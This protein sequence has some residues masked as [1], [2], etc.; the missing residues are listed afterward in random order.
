[1][2]TSDLSCG[3]WDLLW[4]LE[5]SLVEVQELQQLQC[6][7][8]V[9][10]GY[11]GRRPGIEPTSPALQGRYLTPGPPGKSP[12]IPLRGEAKS[13]AESKGPGWWWGVGADRD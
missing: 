4:Q 1:M 12:R 11:C 2:F 7:G 9:A 5:N 13:P 10:P 8:L 6:R 3:T